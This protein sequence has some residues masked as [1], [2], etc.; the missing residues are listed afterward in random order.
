MVSIIFGIVLAFSINQGLA[1]ALSTPMPVVAVE[2]NSMVPTFQKGDILILHGVP[3][4]NLAVG[5]IIVFSPPRQGTPV[6]HRIVRLNSD[7]TFQTRGDANP[8]QLGFEKRIYPEQIQGKV[9]MI[10]PYIGWIK[11]AITEIVLPN[12]LLVIVAALGIFAV[13]K[14]VFRKEALK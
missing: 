13:Y 9:I 6:V 8:G 1:V 11:L 4:E 14:N 10:V 2:S 5:D 3:A 7:G 12:I